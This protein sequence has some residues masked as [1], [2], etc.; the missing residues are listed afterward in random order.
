MS[1]TTTGSVDG[2]FLLV[3]AAHHIVIDP[4]RALHTRTGEASAA[5]AIALVLGAVSFSVFLAL[6]PIGTYVWTHWMPKSF[7][8]FMTFIMVA[9]WLSLP[10]IG[11]FCAVGLA[12]AFLFRACG[13][14]VQIVNPP[15]HRTPAQTLRTFFRALRNSLPQRAYDC[16]TDQAQRQA[17]VLA[18][19]CDFLPG[20]ML[21][22]ASFDSVE[23]FSGYWSRFHVAAPWTA[24]VPA[25]LSTPVLVPF[26]LRVRIQEVDAA[27]V[28]VTVPIL[29]RWQFTKKAQ[30][31]SRW[32]EAAFVMVNR[33][34]SWF[35]TNG[36]LVPCKRLR[37][38]TLIRARPASD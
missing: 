5:V 7:P 8:G 4:L 30:P 33:G 2:A 18:P 28:F 11:A 21:R 25:T 22:A 32:F 37:L 35:L 14:L 6:I 17:R 10:W 24:W 36:Y 15:R 27:T 26:V 1:T 31:S 9:S 20:R 12:V 3:D 38:W 16:L 19:E 13:A 29:A 34:E 23:T